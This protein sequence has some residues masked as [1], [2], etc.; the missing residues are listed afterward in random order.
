MLEDLRV[1]TVPQRPMIAIVRPANAWSGAP[2]ALV[3]MDPVTAKV[4]SVQDPRTASW[5]QAALD[6]LRAA[7]QGGAIGPAGRVLLCLLGIL[8]PLFPVTG[9]AM[10]ILRRRR[11]QTHEAVAMAGR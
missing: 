1:P 10:W 6:W 5:S 7:H 2:R 11:R 3:M 9:L 8:L 4:L